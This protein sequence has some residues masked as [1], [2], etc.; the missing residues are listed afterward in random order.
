VLD[1][2]Q[3]EPEP[4]EEPKL[5]LI[6]DYEE[7]DADRGEQPPSPPNDEATDDDVPPSN[8]VD[9]EDLQ[10][11][12]GDSVSHRRLV[13]MLAAYFSDWNPAMEYVCWEYTHPLEDTY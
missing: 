12:W 7:D 5:I 13:G 6:E 3:P 2:P 4:K 1:P 8:G 11:D 9:C 10:Q